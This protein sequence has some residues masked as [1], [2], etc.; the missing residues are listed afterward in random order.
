MATTQA[1]VD[2]ACQG[3]FANTTLSTS[4]GGGS[5]KTM[6]HVGFWLPSSFATAWY[7]LGAIA[8][9]R[10]PSK[11]TTAWCLLG[12]IAWAIGSGSAIVN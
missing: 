12:A 9:A 5:Q 2:C 8:W 10:P 1:M 11:F 3:C 7:L 4:D 6:A